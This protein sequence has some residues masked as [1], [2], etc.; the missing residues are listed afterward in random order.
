[1]KVVT[2][3]INEF[4][5]A[6]GR[7]AARYDLQLSDDA[8]RRLCVYY[9]LLLAWNARLH[10]VAPC[11]PAE[12]ATRHVR[13]S[14]LLLPQLQLKARVVDIGSG[15]GLPI[16][17][18]LIARPDIQ[19]TL[20]EASAKKCVFLREA[21]RNC[22]ITPQATVIAERFEN[23]AAPA[24][25]YV[26]CRALDRFAQM[27]PSLVRWSPKQSTLLLFGGE[28]LREQIERV[29]L[30]V[31]IVDVPDSERRYLFVCKGR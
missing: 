1:M 12:F 8:I 9:E 19:A 26:T 13:E 27:L 10:L 11:S 3:R 4:R 15:A 23:G 30:E 22:E 29:G 28:S 17:P 18:N 6:M 14:L 20:I 21:L 5:V 7:N 16:I 2:E 25:E 24:V 31:S